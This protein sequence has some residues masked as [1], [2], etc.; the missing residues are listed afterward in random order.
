MVDSS[1]RLDRANVEVEVQRPPEEE[2]G[3]KN[4]ST[5]GS[6][7]DLSQWRDGESP[8]WWRLEMGGV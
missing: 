4:L 8:G 3:D 2:S 6:G 1:S 5:H 7:G